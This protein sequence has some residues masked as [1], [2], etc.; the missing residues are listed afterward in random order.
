MQKTYLEL[1]T[2]L[3]SSMIS[4][5]MIVCP[6]NKDEKWE[7]Y[8]KRVIHV[9][10]W[11]VLEMYHEVKAVPSKPAPKKEVKKSDTKIIRP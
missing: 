1:A 4:K 5:G 11:A 7:A 3:V 2:E 6:R 10:G 9:T 8:N